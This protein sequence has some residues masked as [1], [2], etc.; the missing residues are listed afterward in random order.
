M[1]S[2]IFDSAA[3]RV[4][5]NLEPLVRTAWV[6]HTLSVAELGHDGVIVEVR[7]VDVLLEEDEV[8]IGAAVRVASKK[9]GA[10]N[11]AAFEGEVDAIATSNTAA[12]SELHISIRSN[13]FSSEEVAT[14][15]AW[16][17]CGARIVEATGSLDS[18][19]FLS[20]VFGSPM[21]TALQRLAAHSVVDFFTSARNIWS[22]GTTASI[23]GAIPF[24]AAQN[25]PNIAVW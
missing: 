15:A 19:D 18:S 9:R 4:D 10:T 24:A 21:E 13:E 5:G 7:T 2:L 3:V 8:I 12:G 6:D 14:E 11:V 23:P 1:V 16:A 25:V 17:K 20:S 22:P